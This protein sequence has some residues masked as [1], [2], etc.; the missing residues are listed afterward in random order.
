MGPRCK[1]DSDE[2]SDV[3]ETMKGNLYSNVSS[4]SLQVSTV[5]DSMQKQCV[6]IEF[7][8][9]EGYRLSDTEGL[10]PMVVSSSLNLF[11]HLCTLLLSMVSSLQTFCSLLWSLHPFFVKNSMIVTIEIELF[12]QH[13][14]FE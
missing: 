4:F 10:S 6:T 3:K 5:M 1:M 14:T 7:L 8:T 9:K 11:S 2:D 12:Y 13:V